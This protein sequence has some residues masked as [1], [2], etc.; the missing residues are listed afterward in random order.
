M[1]GAEFGPLITPFFYQDNWYT[2]YV[3][4]TLSETQTI[5]EWDEWVGGPSVVYEPP[6]IDWSNIPIQPYYPWPKNVRVPK[7]GDPGHIDINDSRIKVKPQ[8]RDDWT[9]NPNVYIKYDQ[10]VIGKDTGMN[11]FLNNSNSKAPILVKESDQLNSVLH[12]SS[13]GTN[14]L[15]V[16]TSGGTKISDSIL[17][18]TGSTNTPVL[19]N[20]GIVNTGSTNTVLANTGITT[21]AGPSSGTVLVGGGGIFGIQKAIPTQH[22]GGIF[23]SNI[24][25]R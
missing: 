25:Q 5:N 13:A 4:P 22:L 23:A 17:T 11:V 2:F 19:T 3:E 8:T 16:P 1:G 12:G 20:T 21:V 14:I 15:L 10:R 24:I 18:N 6:K 7:A 9:T